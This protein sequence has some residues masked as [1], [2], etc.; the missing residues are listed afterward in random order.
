MEAEDG[1]PRARPEGLPLSFTSGHGEAELL[2]VF[3]ESLHIGAVGVEAEEKVKRGHERVLWVRT[4]VRI[5][6]TGASSQQT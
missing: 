4:R 2:E 6:R 5:Q 1:F 3:V